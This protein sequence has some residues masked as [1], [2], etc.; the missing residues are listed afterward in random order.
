M[1]ATFHVTDLRDGI[2]MTEKKDKYINRRLT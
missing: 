2:A 1:Y